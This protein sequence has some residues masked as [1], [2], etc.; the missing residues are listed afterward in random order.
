MG[1]R[2]RRRA[3]LRGTGRAY[4]IDVIAIDGSGNIATTSCVVVVP[5]GLGGG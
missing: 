2:R 5:K 4:T 3:L 1:M